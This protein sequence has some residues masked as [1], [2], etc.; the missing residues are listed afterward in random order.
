MI[1]HYHDKTNKFIE[2]FNTK[3]GA[4]IRTGV[5]NDNLK[6]TGVDPFMRDFPALIDIG[7]MGHCV[8][9]ASGLCAKSGVQ[10]YQ[11]GL[12]T[13]DPNMSL[14]NFKKIVDECKNKCFQFALGGRG[15]V[16][17]HEN[18]EE[19]LKY[20]TE[21]DIVPNFTTSGLGLDDEKAEICKKY[22][23]AIAISQ[24]SRLNIFSKLVFRETDT[25]ETHTY[26]NI[27]DIP[28]L[29][30]FGNT[31]SNC[32]FDGNNYIINNI[33]YKTL[34]NGDDLI[35]DSKPQ[36]REMYRVYNE[37]N[38]ENN[39]TFNAVQRLLDKKVKTNIHYVLGKNTIDEAIIRLKFGGFPKGINAVI[40][41]LHKPVGLGKSDN[42]LTP[43]D[44]RVAEFFE[45]VDTQKNHFKIGFDS[46]TIPGILNFTNSIAKES[47]DSC[48]GG[49]YSMYITSDMK[50]LPCS[51]DNQDLKWAYD[52]SNNSIKDAWYSEQ[53][54]D[55]R[56][57]FTQSCLNCKDR[58]SC[59]GGCPI[60]REITLCNR[61]DKNLF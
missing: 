46:C 35:F 27:D 11:N 32:Y 52:I 55:F 57:H 48:E 30:T 8:H 56:N 26:K 36:N 49:R 28:V 24:Y 31:N 1:K 6:D 22:C 17:Q 15:D 13:C 25:N 53:F 58:L 41:L 47:I 7:V 29:F 45:L 59:Y 37:V 54:N 20:C 12:K 18:F 44:P 9:G 2:V 16:D 38:N 51:F 23:G 19:I 4:Y 5:L 50:A 39:Y 42:V 33:K 40:F 60:R 14:E 10:C 21:N 43:D 3:T 61:K 34:E